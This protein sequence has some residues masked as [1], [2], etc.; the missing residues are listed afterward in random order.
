MLRVGPGLN[1]SLPWLQLDSHRE[2]DA[3]VGERS[4]ADHLTLR[5]RQHIALLR[6]RAS[7]DQCNRS[8]RARRS[9]TR[10]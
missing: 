1:R 7:P 10:N 6:I 3:A 9:T 5:E 4:A 8:G 2:A